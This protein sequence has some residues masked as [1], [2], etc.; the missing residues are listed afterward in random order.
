MCTTSWCRD[1]LVGNRRDGCVICRPQRQLRMWAPLFR[2]QRKSIL[3][4]HEKLAFFHRLFNLLLFHLLFHA[5]FS[6]ETVNIL[7]ESMMFT[8]SIM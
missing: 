6:K 5:I 1:R 2:R 7:D 8:V 4:A 3:N